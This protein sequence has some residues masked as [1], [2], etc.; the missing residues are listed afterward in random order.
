M[1]EIL[2]RNFGERPSALKHSLPVRFRPRLGTKYTDF[3]ALRAQ[4]V[5][6]M[7]S[8][9][10]FSTR[11]PLLRL[12]LGPSRNPAALIILNRLLAAR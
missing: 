9:P 8:V 3:G 12:R 10:T 5:V 2:D 1:H 11:W 7:S 4:S 6:A